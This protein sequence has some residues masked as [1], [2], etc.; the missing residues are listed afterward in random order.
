MQLEK[1]P[2]WSEWSNFSHCK[3]SLPTTMPHPVTLGSFSLL[4]A[5]NQYKLPT[6]TKACFLKENEFTNTGTFI[7]NPSIPDVYDG[8]FSYQH[9]EDGTEWIALKLLNSYCE[10]KLCPVLKNVL[11]QDDHHSYWDNKSRFKD[12]GFCKV[13]L[14]SS[15]NDALYCMRTASP[16]W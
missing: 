12:T 15:M 7:C 13:I 14:N 3:N 16:M 4:G 10:A 1:W 2:R 9:G 6:L 11:F 8:C 5:N